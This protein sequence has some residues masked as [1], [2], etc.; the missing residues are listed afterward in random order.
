MNLDELDIERIVQEVVRRL[1]GEVTTYSTA[2][3]T[4]DANVVTMAELHGKL[5]GVQQL[6]IGTQA[7]V[8]PLVRDELNDRKIKIVRA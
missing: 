1:R 4:I 2:V 3:L 6:R 7:I 5:D 8:T